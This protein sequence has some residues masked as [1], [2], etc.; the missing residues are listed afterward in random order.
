MTTLHW[1]AFGIGCQVMVIPV[2]LLVGG[3]V[4]WIHSRDADRKSV[5]AFLFPC[6]LTLAAGVWYVGAGLVTTS[7]LEIGSAE[8]ILASLRKHE[9]AIDSA[10]LRFAVLPA[11]LFAL[12][13]LAFFALKAQV[14]RWVFAG[15]LFLSICG[16]LGF[17][18][19]HLT[20]QRNARAQASL[21]PGQS[22]Y[23]QCAILAVVR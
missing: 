23:S 10:S 2:S 17:L 6:F 14:F 15:V 11:G 20:Q 7:Y 16:Y 8:E 12:A 13:S 5:T 3:V 22:G 21:S 19:A 9:A 4:F 1:I 18:E